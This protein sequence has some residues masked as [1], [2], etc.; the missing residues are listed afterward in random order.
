M[1]NCFQS[2]HSSQINISQNCP[3]HN[4][5]TEVGSAEV[6]LDDDG[7]AE[8]GVVEVG[9]TEDGPA[10]VGSAEVGSAEVGSA[11]EGIAEGGVAEVGSSEVGIAEIWLYFFVLSSPC[12]PGV[13]SLLEQIK[14]LLVCHR[15]SLLCCAHIIEEHMLIC[16]TPHLSY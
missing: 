7:I 2:L 8:V 1:V 3:V 13:N 10:K 14:L 11:E 15:T 5:L 6:G 16:K 12:V 9:S 4:C